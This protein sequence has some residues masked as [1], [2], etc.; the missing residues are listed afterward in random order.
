MILPSRQL[1]SPG[2]VT[3]GI[4]FQIPGWSFPSETNQGR[5]TD[6]NMQVGINNLQA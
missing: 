1:I 2:T 3:D 4:G 5:Q 6:D